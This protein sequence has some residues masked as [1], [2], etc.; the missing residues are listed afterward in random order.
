MQC[1]GHANRERI[2]QNYDVVPVAHLK[3]L[4]G[5]NRRSDAEATIENEYYIFK[6]VD[7]AKGNLID[8]IQ[9][10]MGAAE[11]FFR[12]IPYEKLS[13]FNPLVGDI[14]GRDGGGPHGGDGGRHTVVWN[15]LARQLYYAIMWTIMLINAEPDTPIYNI[16]EK[17]YQYRQYEPYDSKIKGVN[18]IIRKKLHGQ[19]LT[20]AINQ[21]RLD[22]NLRDNM[23]QFDLI[24]AKL[25][26]MTDEDGNA[27]ESYF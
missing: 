9:C 25:D 15:P 27:I 13:I 22:N 11:D 3:L 26:N 14:N 8:T 4:N 16:K 17:V 18:T 2:V 5:E 21:K 10:G 24:Q 20:E 12:M 1:R 23:C 19:T 6:V 7:R